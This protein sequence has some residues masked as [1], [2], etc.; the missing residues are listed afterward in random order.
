MGNAEKILRE[1]LALPEDERARVAQGLLDSLEAPDPHSH[2]TDAE[3]EAML[4]RRAEELSTG[5][6]KGVPWSE[7]KAE[8]QDKLGR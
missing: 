4:L 3:F 2:L 6:V 8:V 7:I 5:V 1:A